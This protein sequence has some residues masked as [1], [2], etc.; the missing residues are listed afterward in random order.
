MAQSGL[1]SR[2]KTKEFLAQHV[3]MIDGRLVTNPAETVAESQLVTVD[4]QKV[5]PEKLEYWILNKPLGVMSSVSDPH[6]KKLVTDYVRSDKRLYPVGRLD[7]DT[8]GLLLL[9]NDGLLAQC[10]THPKYEVVKSYELTLRG[11]I[12][13]DRL[14]PL[15]TGVSLSDGVTLPAKILSIKYRSQQTLVVLAI[16]EGRNRQIRRMCVALNLPLVALRR[17]SLGTME[18]GDLPLGAVR[19]L[20]RQE[21]R[22]LK[23]LSQLTFRTIGV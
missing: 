9:T 16:R 4:G 20:T 21:I 11:R 7:N 5:S 8:T 2:R 18:L 22:D 14:E 1:T 23:Q 3:C 17:I 15:Q 19:K 12:E 13:K 6:A 10:L